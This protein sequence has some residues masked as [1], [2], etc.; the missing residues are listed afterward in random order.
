MNNELK[1]KFV[2]MITTT[3]K[4]NKCTLK[5]CSKLQKLV[6][7]D[8]KLNRMKKMMME[9][10]NEKKREL[11]ITKILQNKKLIDYQRCMYKHCYKLMKDNLKSV[12][13]IIIDFVKLKKIHLNSIIKYQIKNT[14]ILLKKSSL[15]HDELRELSHSSLSFITYIKHHH[16]N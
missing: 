4:L 2:N 16:H 11:L 6:E 10:K 5:N 14:K 7:T 3:L 8:D 9:Q 12:I 15:N 13:N 1:N